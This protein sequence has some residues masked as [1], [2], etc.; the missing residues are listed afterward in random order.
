MNFPIFQNVSLLLRTFRQVATMVVLLMLA[1]CAATST[2]IAY[3]H[4]IQPLITSLSDRTPIDLSQCLL[5]ECKSNDLILYTMERGRYAQIIGNSAASTSDFSASMAK[6][7]END[8][9]ALISASGIGANVAATLV[10]DNAIPYEGE[11]YERVLLHHY[12]ALNYLNKKDIEG[13]G[14]E[15]RR[16]NAEQ[17]DSLKRFEKEVVNAQREATQKKVGGSASRVV[18]QYAQ[19]DEVAGKV[20]NSFQN[21]YTFYL[22]GFIYELLKQPND[23]YI[24]YKKALEIYPENSYLQKDVLRLSTQLAMDDEL[25]ELKQRFP[26][27]T[28]QF[29]AKNSAGSGELL[30]LFEDGFAPQKHEMKIALSLYTGNLVTIAF[31][32]YQEKWS[33]HVPLQVIGNNQFIGYTE[34]ICD[35]RALAVKAL[36]E[37]APVIAT[38]QIIRAVAKEATA[39]E[40]KKQMGDLGQFAANIWSLISENAD[41]RSWLTLPS[42]AQIL[43]TTI[44]AGRYKLALQHPMAGMPAYIHVTITAGGKSVLQVV[45]T[46]RE[47]YSSVA[48]F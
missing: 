6:I 5:N 2:F 20:K 35:V 29:V 42:N 24:D 9:K 17:E 47:I 32:I 8:A 16:A 44:P 38:R 27:D 11:G 34:P 19:M 21:A 37:Q 46:G 3:P 36:K 43:R 10:N 23:A 33:S 22:S 15:V 40:A 13:A 18:S 39:A 25:L 30:V 7:A 26:I 14:V 1:G 48:Q 12:Q 45:R 31:P 41:L 4:K 28:K